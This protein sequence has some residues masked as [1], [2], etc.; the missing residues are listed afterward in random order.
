M[1]GQCE[2][3]GRHAEL[4]CAY[5]EETGEELYLCETCCVLINEDDPWD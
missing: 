5:N 1:E 4:D 3:C 2:R